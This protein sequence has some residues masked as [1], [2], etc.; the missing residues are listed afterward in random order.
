MVFYFIEKNEYTDVQ[1]VFI[2]VRVGFVTYR[3]NQ[4]YFIYSFYY[5]KFRNVC[6]SAEYSL[7]I[8]K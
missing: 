3:L 8:V 5:K 6:Y 2:D 4:L 1:T 7:L